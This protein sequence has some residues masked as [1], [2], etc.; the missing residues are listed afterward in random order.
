MEHNYE[1]NLGDNCETPVHSFECTLNS[2][3]NMI[4]LCRT[5]KRASVSGGSTT[6]I[7]RLLISLWITMLGVLSLHFFYNDSEFIASDDPGSD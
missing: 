3:G 2:L 5:S 6:V 1:H 4:L 7:H